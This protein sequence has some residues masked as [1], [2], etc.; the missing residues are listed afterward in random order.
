MFS[1]SL[2]NN[3]A[4]GL[5]GRQA[6]ASTVSVQ[7]IFGKK[8]KAAP[9]KE[10]KP[11]KKQGFLS[12]FTDAI[13]FAQVRSNDDRDLIDGAK[14]KLGAKR[15]KGQPREK[16]SREQYQAL[17]RKVGGTARDYWKDFV[18]ADE[19]EARRSSGV[20]LPTGFPFLLAIV[21]GV[22][23]ATVVVS[24]SSTPTAAPTTGPVSSQPAEVPSSFNN[25][26]PKGSIDSQP[27]QVTGSAAS[28]VGA[29][30]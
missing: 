23:V 9:K 22:I 21:A 4:C 11:E 5:Q 14:S 13:D 19:V 15:Q 30:I 16:M 24:Q 8:K 20:S 10:K 6:R 2:L 3:R 17:R 27:S 18:E 1:Q 26:P 28:A 25:A 29:E 7:A 12:Q